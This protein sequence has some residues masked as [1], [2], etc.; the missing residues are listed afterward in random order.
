MD[1]NSLRQLFSVRDI[2]NAAMGTAVVV[3]GLGLAGLTVV[4]HRMN[5]PRLAGI[6]AGISLVFILIILI[7]VVPPLAKSASRE[8][9]QLNLPFD[10]TLGGGIMFGLVAIVGFSAWNTGNNLLFLVFSFM[11]AAMVVGLIAG[12]ISLKKLDVKMRFPETIFAGEETQVFVS[13]QNRK[14][15]FSSYSVVAEV[16]GT[17]RSESVAAGELRRLLPARIAE[18]LA[19]PP[20][21]RRTLEYFVNVP[22]SSTV[23]ARAIHIFDRRGRFLIKDFEV[24]SKYPFAF[25]RHRR[26]LPAMETELVVLPSFEQFRPDSVDL[27]LDAGKLVAS[28]RGSG[29][30]LLTLREYQINDDIRRVDWKATARS[31]NIIVREFAAE[32]DKLITIF[33]DTR[34][35]A[36]RRNRLPLRTLIEA[37]QKGRDL[38]HSERF[39]RGISQAASLLA[40]FTEEQAEIRLIIGSAIGE[41]GMGNR[42]LY[43]S[44]RRIA[45]IEP[46]YIDPKGS[47]EVADDVVELFGEAEFSHNFVVSSLKSSMFA[48]KMLNDANFVR[49]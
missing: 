12:S 2:R 20:I 5:E 29:Q 38:T 21:I 49:F 13:V 40:H 34:M 44:L 45:I 39:E 18:P 22:R 25:F 14:R 35:P 10:L 15:I 8:A 32:D 3:G 30:E 41:Y 46:E 48:E 47:N 27:H 6:S 11:V 19:K 16:R 33:F 42:H 43:E 23:E 36:G 4:A 1:L 17:E 31:G 7:F 9:S 24:S 26:R 28:K 37:E